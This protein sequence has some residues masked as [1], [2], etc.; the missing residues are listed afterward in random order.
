MSHIQGLLYIYERWIR[1]RRDLRWGSFQPW[2]C[3]ALLTVKG[4]MGCFTAECEFYAITD[5]ESRQTLSWAQN[6]M[7]H[8]Q[9]PTW[10]PWPVPGLIIP[11]KIFKQYRL[12]CT[13]FY[14]TLPPPYRGSTDRKG[15]LTHTHCLTFPQSVPL[16]YLT[17]AVSSFR[18]SA[19]PPYNSRTNNSA[20][21]H[22][23]QI[24]KTNI[25]SESKPFSHINSQ[26]YFLR[27]LDHRPAQPVKQYFY[28]S[29]SSKCNAVIMVNKI[30]C[31]GHSWQRSW[32]VAR[33][34]MD[35]AQV[36]LLKDHYVQLLSFQ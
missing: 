27:I 23:Y 17:G 12:C 31:N 7:F 30:R 21:Q 6:R 2:K 35:A 20:W 26:M 32:I 22:I 33:P 15:W 19:F 25:C 10:T 29:K 36:N 11:K 34:G 24:I 18:L 9:S 14:P 28:C 13:T 4:R 16:C 3:S 5:D 8:L 1:E